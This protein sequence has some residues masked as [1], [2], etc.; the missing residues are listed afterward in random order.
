MIPGGNIRL[1]LLSVGIA[2]L[3]RR[4]NPGCIPAG[5]PLCC[6]HGGCG[7]PSSSPYCYAIRTD[8][9][10]CV[11]ASGSSPV[12]RVARSCRR[13]GKKKRLQGM[14]AA[15]KG[16]VTYSPTFAVP[17]AWRGL[18][19]LF[20]MGRG[21]APALSPPLSFCLCP[22]SC[23][24]VH[25]RCV[26]GKTAVSDLEAYTRTVSNLSRLAFLI[27][28]LCCRGAEPRERVRAISNARL[29]ALLHLHLRPINVV[30][31]NDPNVEILSWGGLRA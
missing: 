25:D 11:G 9:Q 20:G 29:C 8:P 14:L 6:N 27:A 15:S 28:S 30:V 4:L 16:A 7:L 3:N 1:R 5:Y 12:S 31:Y 24:A 18:T 10:A 21:G 26:S 2:A 23:T 17:S 19:S 22:A 13:T